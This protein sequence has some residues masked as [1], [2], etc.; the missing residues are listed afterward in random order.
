[1]RKVIH[2]APLKIKAF[3]TIEIII[4]ETIGKRGAEGAINH[5]ARVPSERHG[6][7]RALRALAVEILAVGCSPDLKVSAGRTGEARVR[8]SSGCWS[9]LSQ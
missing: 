6:W 5:A 2:A 9:W 1:M 4:G 3:R 7:R 8:S